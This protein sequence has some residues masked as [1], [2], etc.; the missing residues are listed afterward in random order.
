MGNIVNVADI[1]HSIRSGAAIAM[2]LDEVPVYTI[3]LI[4]RWSS[5][6]FLRYIRKKVEQFSHNVSCRMIKNQHFTH[7][8]HS[9]S[10]SHLDPLHRNHRDNAQTQQNM[11]RGAGYVTRTLPAISMW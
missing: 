3:M 1:P 6:A 8:P 2:Y 10:T 4:G 5:D 11:G 7:I 9:R